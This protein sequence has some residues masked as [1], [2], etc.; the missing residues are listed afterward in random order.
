MWAYKSNPALPDTDFDG[1]N[2]NLDINRSLENRQE[3]KMSTLNY[4]EAKFNFNQDYRYFF[5]PSD[6]Y[7]YDLSEM[8]MIQS[9]MVNKK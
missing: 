7:Y 4:E 8:S 2:D 5:M 1:R 6:R 9:N 3:G